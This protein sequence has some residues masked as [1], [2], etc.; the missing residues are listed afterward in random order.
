MRSEPPPD[1]DEALRSSVPISYIEVDERPPP[2][3]EDYMTIYSTS[4]NGFEDN[5]VDL[6]LTSLPDNSRSQ[7]NDKTWIRI[8]VTLQLSISN[9]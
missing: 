3:Y 8:I 1:F 5:F 9:L 4:N 7:T 6:S 2:S